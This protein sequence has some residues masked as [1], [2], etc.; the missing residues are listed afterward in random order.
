[1][2]RVVEIARNETQETDV[3]KEITKVLRTRGDGA[4]SWRQ[5]KAMKEKKKKIGC[6]W[7]DKKETEAL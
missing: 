5:D 6:Y 2:E 4:P 3:L 1:M 7:K